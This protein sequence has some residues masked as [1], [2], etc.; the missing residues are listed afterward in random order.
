M[1]KLFLI[2]LIFPAFLF[3]QSQFEESYDFFGKHYMASFYGCDYEA[4]SNHTAL[5]AAV[6]GASENS[7]VHVLGTIDYKFLPQ[8]Y[9]MIVMLP[10]SHA[11]IHTYPEYSVCFI[12]YFTSGDDTSPRQ[13]ENRLRDYLSPGDISSQIIARR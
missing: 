12:D 13:F 5:K 2:T 9:T 7:G 8:G 3:A 11:S 10:E 1:K 4:L 6:E